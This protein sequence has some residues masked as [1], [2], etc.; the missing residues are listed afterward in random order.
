MTH[1]QKTDA[2]QRIIVGFVDGEQQAEHAVGALI[3]RDF[4]PDRLSA[5]GSAGS[6][7]DD[8]LGIYYKSAGER[9]QGWG[10][11]GAIWGGIFGLLSGAAGLF[12]VPGV[13]ALMAAGPIAEALIGA[14]AGAGVG[15]GVM[16]G[17]AALTDFAVAV[18]Q[19][20]VPGE[21]LDDMHRLIDQ[22][23][24]AILLIVDESEVAP[25]RELLERHGAE[26]VW[27]FPYIG[28]A[29]VVEKAVSK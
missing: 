28:L 14:A 23:R 20:G 16:A 29:D 7:G 5:L 25:W 21:R 10:R 24:Y 18:H 19:M 26:P 3:D 2:K 17:G 22:G 13:G 8:P 1:V 12:I 11:M 6:S 27:V 15:A 9:I 4:P